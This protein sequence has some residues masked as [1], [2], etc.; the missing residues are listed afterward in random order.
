M[1][2][3]KLTGAALGAILCGA[4][5][6]SASVSSSH[7]GEYKIVN[8]TIPASLTGKAGDAKKGRKLAISK[9]KGNCLACHVMPIPE[10]Q[11][12]G[13]IGPDLT[14]VADY[15]TEAEMRMRMVDPK[16]LNPE[17]IMPSFLKVHTT[18]VLKKFKGKTILKAQ[19]VEDIIA[20]LK[21]L[22]G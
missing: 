9:K 15:M 16:V 3:S 5:V 17:T 10:Q 7:A 14:G 2:Y 12:H 1:T 22:K 13:E 20:Y 18:R 4:L 6:T 21:T 8:S 19:E 11:F